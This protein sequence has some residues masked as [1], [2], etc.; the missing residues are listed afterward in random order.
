LRIAANKLKRFILMQDYMLEG[1]QK[2]NFVEEK[3]DVLYQLSYK[4]IMHCAVS[5][6]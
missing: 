6:K 3:V 1:R 4:E 2:R 5:V